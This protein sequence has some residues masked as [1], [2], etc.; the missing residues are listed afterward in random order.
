[1]KTFDSVK[2]TKVT[3]SS[4]KRPSVEI[5]S[6]LLIHTTQPF[7][8]KEAAILRTKWNESESD[9]SRDLLRQ[10]RKWQEFLLVKVWVCLNN[11]EKSPNIA[12]N[13][14]FF[15]SKRSLP[16]C[17]DLKPF[18]DKIRRI[19]RSKYKK[20]FIIKFN[21]FFYIERNDVSVYS[22]DSHKIPSSY[23][24]GSKSHHDIPT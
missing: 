4:W 17:V 24:H 16:V 8:F 9:Y 20:I 1:M 21:R 19:S 3:L 6:Q 7:L 12:H 23:I 18:V 10:V 2:A 11:Q 14:S 15:L 13:W 5:N 22:I